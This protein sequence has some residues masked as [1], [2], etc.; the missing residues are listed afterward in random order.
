MGS[1]PFALLAAATVVTIGSAVSVIAWWRTSVS[2]SRL[3]SMISLRA[4]LIEIRDYVSK[5]DAWAKR[6]NARE[7]MQE[8]REDAKTNGATPTRS[9]RARSGPETKDDLR[10][11]AGIVAGRPVQHSED[12]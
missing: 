8:R 5:I 3:R 1:V 11:R 10:R 6:I 12:V 4:E 2:V 9:S 7:V